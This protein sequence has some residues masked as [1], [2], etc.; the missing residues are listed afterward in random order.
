METEQNQSGNLVD[1]LARLDWFE[2]QTKYRPDIDFRSWAGELRPDPEIRPLNMAEVAALRSLGGREEVDAE[3]ERVGLGFLIG[4]D[5]RRHQKSEV[6]LM[7]TELGE[8]AKEVAKKARA[9]GRE[10]SGAEGITRAA[11]VGQFFLDR[12]GAAYVTGYYHQRVCDS[13][14]GW[15]DEPGLDYLTSGFRRALGPSFESHHLHGR[16]MAKKRQG[17]NLLCAVAMA[18]RCEDPSNS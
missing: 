2:L 5:E 4:K 17:E 9:W 7:V 1:W 18:W 12:A 3:M 13:L 10:L 14:K 16:E 6:A 11:L 15:A 8:G